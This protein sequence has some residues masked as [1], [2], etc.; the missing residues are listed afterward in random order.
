VK[1]AIASLTAADTPEQRREAV[2]KVRSLT[3]SIVGLRDV[4]VIAEAVAALDQLLGGCDDPDLVETI[5]S[6]AAAVADKATVARMV[7]RLGEQRVP[8]AERDVLVTALG[9]LASLSVVPVLNAYL[10]APVDLRE[11]YRAVIRRAGDRALEPLQGRLADNDGAIA[12]AA[13]ELVGLT[14]VPQVVA[15]LVPLLRHE[16]EFVREAALNGLAEIGGREISRP[17]MPALKDPSVIVR[18]A[19][20]RAIAVGGEVAATTVLVR[21]LEQEEDESVLAALLRAIARLGSRE[22]LEVLAK[23]AEPGGMMHRRSPMVRAAAVESLARITSREARGLVE[24]YAHDKEPA[25][26]K[27][28]EAALR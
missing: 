13:A 17:V 12:A 11:P 21:R 23:Y 7:A 20:A 10:S 8:P 4:A 14:G 27:A 9:A 26:R 2:E 3:P 5:G 6:V 15:L 25:V 18:A 19:A 22:A 1:R 16:S 24:L 28:A